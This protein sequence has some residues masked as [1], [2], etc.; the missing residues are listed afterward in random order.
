MASSTKGFIKNFDKDTVFID[1]AVEIKVTFTRDRICSDPFGIVSTLVRIHYV[2][3]GPALNWNGTIPHRI[4]F[5]SGPIWYQ[6]A[7]P[8][9]TGSTKSRVNTRL[10][11][12]NFVLAWFQTDPAPCKRCLNVSRRIVLR[13]NFRQTA[14]LR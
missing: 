5:I 6:I 11:R 8:I 10:I 14:E 13:K 2:Y 9:R 7:D 1:F 4:T 3:T 12:T